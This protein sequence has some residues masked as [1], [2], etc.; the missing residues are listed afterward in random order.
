M[1]GGPH[2]KVQRRAQQRARRKAQCRGGLQVLPRHLGPEGPC[3]GPAERRQ[4][5]QGRSKALQ[6]A[7]PMAPSQRFAAAGEVDRALNRRRPRSWATARRRER[8]ARRARGPIPWTPGR[9]APGLFWVQAP[10]RWTRLPPVAARSRLCVR[11]P[12]DRA[13]APAR[14]RAR[15]QTQSRV[16]VR[17]LAASHRQPP[18]KMSPWPLCS[19][20]RRSWPRDASLRRRRLRNPRQRRSAPRA[21]RHAQFSRQAPVVSSRGLR[22]NCRSPPA[23][24]EHRPSDPS[25]S[26]TSGIS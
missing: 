6:T 20:A 24:A 11:G 21:V 5:L 19:Q 12:R 2:R 15:G 10:E 1:P 26:R 23:P 25:P 4:G 7:R 18:R 9:K 22:R 3:R 17:A 8:R 16:R 14:A 13:P